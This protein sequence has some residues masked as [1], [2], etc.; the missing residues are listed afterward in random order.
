M[1]GFVIGGQGLQA[2]QRAP[3][4]GWRASTT[5]LAGAW[6]RG[7]ENGIRRIPRTNMPTL[8]ARRWR[9]RQARCSTIS[10]IFTFYAPTDQNR[11]DVGTSSA[12]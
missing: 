11:A 8:C 5:T 9:G 3:P 6:N 10:R 4:N 1:N 2:A 12:W 7:P